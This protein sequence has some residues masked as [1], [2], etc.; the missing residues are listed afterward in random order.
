MLKNDGHS[1]KEEGDQERI[2]L[3]KYWAGKGAFTGESTFMSSADVKSIKTA[4]TS[5]LVHAEPVKVAIA[6]ISAQVNEEKRRIAVV[7]N[8]R[9]IEAGRRWAA[10]ARWSRVG[11]SALPYRRVSAPEVYEPDPTDLMLGR[12]FSEFGD[13]LR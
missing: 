12:A 9:S 2:F 8:Q 4:D 10:I 1:D 11:E 7:L 3:F 5:A 6:S 13:L